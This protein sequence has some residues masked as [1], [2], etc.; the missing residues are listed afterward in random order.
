MKIVFLDRDG[1]I[2]EFPGNGRYVTKVKD[3]YFIP[4]A[5]EAIGNLTRA[6]YT[7][8]VVS[9]QAGVSKG[10]FTQK[11][12]DMITRKMLK[13][14]KAAGGRIR[15][16]FYSIQTR[17]AGDPMRKPNTGSIKKA[18]QLLKRGMR[19]ARYGYFVGDT[20]VDILTG[21][22]AGCKTIFVLS[23][24]EDVLYMRRWDDIEP[25]YIVKDL[26]EA[27]K[28]ITGNGEA[29]IIGKRSKLARILTNKRRRKI[30]GINMGRRAGDT[31]K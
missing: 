31:R 25:D 8:F 10:L 7:I 28:L 1:V 6:G 26:L 24:R 16:V 20:E 21:K 13:G 3:F 17:D 12:L 9:N 23:G 11:K 14:V 30:G 29:Q 19:D 15:K 2:N 22:N 18:M 4:G 27:S 5:L